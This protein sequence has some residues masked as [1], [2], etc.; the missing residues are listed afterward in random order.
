MDEALEQLLS[1]DQDGTL[2]FRLRCLAAR[3]CPVKGSCRK[4]WSVT[5]I[6]EV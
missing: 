1:L 5:R 2:C 3:G 6:E 4:W